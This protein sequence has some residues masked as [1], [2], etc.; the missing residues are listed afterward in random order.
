MRY[1]IS[2][3]EVPLLMDCLDT[4]LSL[5]QASLKETNNEGQDSESASSAI[6]F[7]AIANKPAADS[8]EG[9]AAW[10]WRLNFSSYAYIFKIIIIFIYRMLPVFDFLT[11]GILDNITYNL[12][13][14]NI[15]SVLIKTFFSCLIQL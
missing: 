14:K 15:F 4:A 2:H 11:S 3:A 5:Y 8:V 6:D 13:Q 9:I 12:L 10:N 7:D 1:A